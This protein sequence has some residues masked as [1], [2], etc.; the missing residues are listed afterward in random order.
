M[1]RACSS[2]R[3]TSES[4]SLASPAARG[5]APMPD[6]EV[7]EVLPET[8]DQTTKALTNSSAPPHTYRFCWNASRLPPP[9][10]RCEPGGSIAVARGWENLSL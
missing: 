4:R 1:V 2:V 10:S 6:E 8:D 9:R 5:S 3:C 7:G